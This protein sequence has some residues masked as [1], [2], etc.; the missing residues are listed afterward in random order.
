[1]N[2]VKSN[3]VAIQIAYFIQKQTDN[4]CIW[5]SYDLSDISKPGHAKMKHEHV[6]PPKHYFY[7]LIYFLLV[8]F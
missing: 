6:L 7:L 1:M 8:L 3:I 5:I 2:K 4:K